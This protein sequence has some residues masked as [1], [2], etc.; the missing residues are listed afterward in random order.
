VI[1]ENAR[2]LFVESGF[3]WVET[4]RR[5]SC[6]SCSVSSGCGTSVVAK[7]FGER[8]NRLRV[9]DGIGV[10]VGDRVVIGIADAA[11]IRA[12]VLAYLLPL[13]ALMST[14]FAAQAAWAEDGVVAMFGILGLL[15]GLWLTGLLTGTKS[16]RER[17]GPVLLHRLDPQGIR[18]EGPT[19]ET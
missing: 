6:S 18:V 16:A 10:A 14:A 4:A 12:S 9:S 17:F 15:A 13:V 1:E 5:S 11:L 8:T 3:A 2:V 19:R 7:L